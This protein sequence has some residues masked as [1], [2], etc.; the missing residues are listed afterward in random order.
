M[1]WDSSTR[2]EIA[3]FKASGPST[4]TLAFSPDG[5]WLAAGSFITQ[6]T[7]VWNLAN[8]EQVISLN[9]AADQVAFAPDGKSLV[10]CS[11]MGNAAQIWELPSGRH[12]AVLKGHVGGMVEVAF[13]PDGRTLATGA[14]D[15]RNKLWNIAIGQEVATFPYEGMMTGLRFS[16]D[17]RTL[18][19]SLWAFPDYRVLLFRAP[20]IN[21][22]AAAEKER[23]APP[24]QP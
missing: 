2:T 7:L 1:I 23:I 19:T 10:T 22:I 9:V 12:K 24:L 11:I 17:E 3:R 21:E 4:K 5:K 16:P 20:S 6:K 18:A 15:G 14:Y 13:S 8:R